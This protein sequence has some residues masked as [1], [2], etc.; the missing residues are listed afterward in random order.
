M[1]FESLA[2]RAIMGLRKFSS[3]VVLAATTPTTAAASTGAGS[4]GAGQVKFFHPNGAG[5]PG[6]SALHTLADGLGTWAM[7]FAL[8][9][10]VIGAA[11]WAL[12]AHS[13]NYHQS[14]AGRRAVLVSGAAALLVGA[15]PGI[16]AF[17]FNTGLTVK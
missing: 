13:Q 14:V 15:A 9:G 12:G 4:T 8:V 17:F 1:L 11:V 5:L 2:L 16:I 10:L 7:I 6:T 3:T